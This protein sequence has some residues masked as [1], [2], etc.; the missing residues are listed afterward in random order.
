LNAISVGSGVTDG[1]VTP[2]TDGVKV[3]GMV[4]VGLADGAVDVTT[5]LGLASGGCRG[6]QE[7]KMEKSKV[8]V[9]KRLIFL[10]RLE[11]QWK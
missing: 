6:V 8:M 9:N 4:L 5:W 10:L 3:A 7:I 11:I 1:A 2:D